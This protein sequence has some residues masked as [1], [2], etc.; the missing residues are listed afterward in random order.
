MENRFK[1][2]VIWLLYLESKDH[3]SHGISWTIVHPVRDA[4]AKIIMPVELLVLPECLW[5]CFQWSYYLF[6]HLYA[7]F[8]NF[9]QQWLLIFYLSNLWPLSLLEFLFR[10]LRA[11]FAGLLLH[12][13]LE[14]NIPL[15]LELDPPLP[16]PWIIDGCVVHAPSNDVF[17][18]P[19]PCSWLMTQAY[20]SSMV[21]LFKS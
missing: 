7:K 20:N 18:I 13:T 1:I 5:P 11:K 10:P 3:M 8:Q 9:L 2:R 17:D 14:K 16:L 4:Q 6:L 19:I 21:K 15:T 12:H